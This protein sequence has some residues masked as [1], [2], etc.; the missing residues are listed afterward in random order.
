MAA[1]GGPT[2][3][4]VT[5]EILTAVLDDHVPFLEAGMPAIDLIDFKYGSRPE[6]NDYW[7]T[8]ADTLDKLSADSL[9]TVGRVILR[10]V[11]KLFAAE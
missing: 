3:N 1:D 5:I 8:D 11:N 7:H 2:L 6:L 10:T 9:Q 4:P